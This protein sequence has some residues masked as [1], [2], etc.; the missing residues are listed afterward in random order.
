[1]SVQMGDMLPYGNFLVM[2]Q[3]GVEEV[4]VTNFFADKTVL[5]F[6]VPGAF[7]PTCSA[8]H[9]PGYVEH[10]QAFKDKGVDDIVCLAVNDVFVMNAWG[11]QHNA[12]Q[13]VM[14]SD[15]LAEFTQ[16]LGLEIEVA[17]AKMGLRSRRYA[18]LVENGVIQ[19]LW[20]EEPG[21][22]GISSAEQVLSHL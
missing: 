13:I 17:T 2:G 15:N 3:E 9:L 1:M 22:F 21:E 10:Y 4:D 8:R 16:A 6:A 12:D 7:T 5:L 20:L 11:K 18:M 19:N 14:A